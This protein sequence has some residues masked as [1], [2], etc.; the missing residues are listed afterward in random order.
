MINVVTPLALAAVF[1]LGFSSSAT[2]QD[3]SVAGSDVILATIE[4]P[5]SREAL[6]ETRLSLESEGHT[7]NYGSFQFGPNGQL[8]GAEVFLKVD[9]VEHQQYIEFVTDDCRLLVLKN[10]GLLLE[11]C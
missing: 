3:A 7:F 9:G 4:A 1:A 11:G 2:A 5:M 10:E 8:I 6:N